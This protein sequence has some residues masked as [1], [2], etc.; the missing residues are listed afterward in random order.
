M[1]TASGPFGWL[2]IKIDHYVLAV[3]RGRPAATEVTSVQL[4][5]WLPVLAASLP[6]AAWAVRADRRR[7]LRSLAAAGRCPV[8]GYDLRATADRCPECGRQ[9]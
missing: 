8:C 3:R 7:R 2:D 6:L 1:G 4:P 5:L 9:R